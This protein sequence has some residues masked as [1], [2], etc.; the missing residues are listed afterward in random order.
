MAALSGFK[1]V[2]ISK[3]EPAESCTL[4]ITES[5][6]RFN[7]AAVAELKYPAFVKILINEETKQIAIQA[8]RANG[9]NSIKFSKPV[10]KQTGSVTLRVPAVVDAIKAFFDLR[11]P[12]ELEVDTRV[13]VGVPTANSDAIIFNVS[14]ADQVISK[15]RGRRKTTAA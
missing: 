4:T 15:R 9:V 8:S 1:E 14:D 13:I 3:E 7:K 10:E 5:F 2:V 6:V 12:S 11:N